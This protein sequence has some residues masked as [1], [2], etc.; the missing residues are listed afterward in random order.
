MA[1]HP[2][3]RKTPTS[4]QVF[5]KVHGEFRS[6]R[7]PL[8]TSISDLKRERDRLKTQAY[9]GISIEADVGEG[10]AK[11]ATA[12]LGLVKGMASYE[13]RAYEINAWAKAF[14]S[15]PRWGIKGRDIRTVLERW[16]LTGKVDGTGLSLASLNRRRTSLMHLWTVLDGKSAANPVKDV[17]A[18]RE[19]RPM[20]TLPSLEEAEA[21]IAKVGARDKISKS[22]ARLQAL[23]WTGW[24]PAQLMQVR[25][26]DLNLTDGVAL[27][28]GRRKGTGTRDRR[29]PLLPQAVEALGAFVKAE[30]FGPF[31]TSALHSSLH[32]ACDNAEVPRFRVYDLR[33]LFATTVAAATQDDR[34]VAELLLHSGVGQTA[35]Y[36]EQSVSE[37]LRQGL[38]RVVQHLKIEAK[39]AGRLPT[40]GR[41]KKQAGKRSA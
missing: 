18:Y 6:K 22:R 33:H 15:R 9:Y 27:V 25:Q 31:S 35:R 16:R 41:A 14:G 10:F 29:L 38:D 7:F 39:V 5:A 17:P 8:D 13:D 36:T 24:P 28:R 20:L 21:A 34:V 26:A 11:D 32:T 1:E 23:L 40:R 30:A 19:V 12:Y 3:I 37:R 4:W 2:G